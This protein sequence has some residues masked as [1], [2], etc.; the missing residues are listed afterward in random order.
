M[1]VM[2]SWHRHYTR[3]AYIHMDYNEDD[4]FEQRAKRDASEHGWDFERLQG[5]HRLLKELLRGE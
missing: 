4:A 1:K 3:A 2:G 5:N